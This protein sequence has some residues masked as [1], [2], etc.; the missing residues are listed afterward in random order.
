MQ[1]K[2]VLVDGESKAQEIRLR[3]PM[4]VGRG[5]G[6]KLQLP[7]GLVSRQHCELYEAD[8]KL[9]VKD[10][11]SLNGTYV[12]NERITEA[13]VPNGQLITIGGVTFRAVYG[14][15]D[16]Q[17][18]PDLNGTVEMSATSKAAS[19]KS[20]AEDDEEI[21][22]DFQVS[23]DV[24]VVEEADLDQLLPPGA[25]TVPSPGPAAAAPSAPAIG[26]PAAAAAPAPPPEE[27]DAD[28]A[29][30]DLSMFLKSLGQK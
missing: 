10:L 7:H 26:P 18:P 19:A 9:M 15:E 11:G 1:A 22:I 8:G 17:L 16:E 6:A 20:S 21:P 4:I 13:V 30:E 5:K 23:E 27:A 14:G 3:L 12:N 2:L 25:E 28:A 24:E 29:D